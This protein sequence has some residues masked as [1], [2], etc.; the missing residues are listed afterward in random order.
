[1]PCKGITKGIQIV[2]L[3]WSNIVMDNHFYQPFALLSAVEGWGKESALQS[4]T[5]YIAGANAKIEATPIENDTNK[6]NRTIVRSK[7]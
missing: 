2:L 1:M 6:K 4:T 3:L 7:S 5:H